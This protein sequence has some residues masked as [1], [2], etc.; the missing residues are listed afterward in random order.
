MRCHGGVNIVKTWD[1]IRAAADL[2]EEAVTER[3]AE[4][5]D[6]VKANAVAEGPAETS[7]PEQKQGCARK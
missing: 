7:T 3:R 5:E 6:Q 4:L 2:D 1:E